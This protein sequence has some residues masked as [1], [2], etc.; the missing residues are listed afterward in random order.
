MSARSVMPVAPTID[1]PTTASSSAEPSG[2]RTFDFAKLRGSLP[3]LIPTV[4]LT[5][6]IALGSLVALPLAASATTQPWQV[7]SVS[8]ASE[9]V[10]TKA[11]VAHASRAKVRTPIKRKP[12]VRM[13]QVTRDVPVGPSES[14]QA[15]WYGG[16]W[17]GRI[18]SSGEVFRPAEMTAAHKYLPFGTRIRVCSSWACVIVR[19][20]D[21]GPYVAGRIVDLSEGAAGRMGM[22]GSGV[23]YVTLTPIATKTYLEPVVA[24]VR[25]A[26]A[27]PRVVRASRSSRGE[28][29]AHVS[30][31]VTASTMVTTSGAGAAGGG[32]ALAL[33]P[34]TLLATAAGLRRARTRV[35]LAS[36][37]DFP[38]PVGPEAPAR[39][40]KA[41]PAVA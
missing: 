25:K 9:S 15:S 4:G 17:A 19:V 32:A 34:L 29:P 36:I 5:G 28:L 30:P 13:H 10:Y 39:A 18:T 3:P 1:L 2:S 22:L 31:A 12:V 41:A 7:V 23:A 14:G 38:E 26:A 8:S 37:P 27:K 16:N 11:P 21:R 6:A 40:K 24:P 35:E 33:T 20:T